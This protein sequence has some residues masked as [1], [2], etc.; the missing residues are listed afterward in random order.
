MPILSGNANNRP[1][2]RK[3]FP[4]GP[5]TL[6]TQAWLFFSLYCLVVLALDNSYFLTLGQVLKLYS[7]GL[8][9]AV[10]LF[11]LFLLLRL[12]HMSFACMLLLAVLAAGEAFF[13]VHVLATPV[14]SPLSWKGST[15]I[16]AGIATGAVI[17]LLLRLCASIRPFVVLLVSTCLL[18]LALPLFTRTPATPAGPSFAPNVLLISLDAHRRDHLGSYADGWEGDPLYAFLTR[19]GAVVFNNH[20]CQSPQTNPSHATMFTGQLPSEHGVLTNGNALPDRAV[21]LAEELAEQGFH[22]YAVISGLPMH[23]AISHQDQGFALYHQ[24]YAA[25]DRG[26]HPERLFAWCAGFE[27]RKARHTNQAVGSLLP[28]LQRAQPFFLFLHYFDTHTP[29][30]PEQAPG[31]PLARNN[32]DRERLARLLS[33]PLRGS[34]LRTWLSPEYGISYVKR[35]Y[36]REAEELHAYVSDLL[37]EM[38]RLGLL[39]DT[40]IILT[41]DHGESLDEHGI[42][43][44][45]VD[46][47]YNQAVHVPFILAGP[48]RAA[49]R[50]VDRLTGHRLI[51]PLVSFWI[52]QGR[53]PDDFSQLL[54]T[55]QPVF[56]ELFGKKKRF[57]IKTGAVYGDYKMIY[58]GQN[59]ETFDRINDTAESRILPPETN[60]WLKRILEAHFLHV[61]ETV[62]QEKHKL[63]P[64][65]RSLGY[66]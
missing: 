23:A 55:D 7:Y 4:S 33:D 38:E 65:L 22:T 46:S 28:V 31:G 11:A 35:L 56:F 19:K 60:P 66:L 6:L 50:S 32:E 12:I 25:S 16:L 18:A 59:H 5:A 54:T 34:Y 57:Y 36:R 62:Q 58:D 53:L 47:P 37:K 29:Y 14:Y 43:F 26:F 10:A 64:K 3:P 63:H 52:S 40:L 51:R 1:M 45:H 24:K 17:W 9:W 15:H 42:Y 8:L 49:V 39:A 2:A 61:Q 27:K 48:E 41:A 30:Q 13:R 20:F 44:D 21:T